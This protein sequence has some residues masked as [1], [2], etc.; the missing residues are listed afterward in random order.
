M[1]VWPLGGGITQDLILKCLPEGIGEMVNPFMWENDQHHATITCSIN[2]ELDCEDFEWW[3]QQHQVSAIPP[4]NSSVAIN[5]Q[6][7]NVMIQR[8][9]MM[10]KSKI[11]VSAKN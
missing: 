8:R 10:L 9:L 5:K 4:S 2:S 1:I 11:R 6:P 3:K 7:N